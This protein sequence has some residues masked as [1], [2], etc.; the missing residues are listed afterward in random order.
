MS[1]TEHVLLLEFCF[2][3]EIRDSAFVFHEISVVEIKFIYIS[4]ELITFV[5][6]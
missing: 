5:S 6:T 3:E 2:M 1:S 4:N